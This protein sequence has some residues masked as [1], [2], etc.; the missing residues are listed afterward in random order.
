VAV[1][2][3]GFSFVPGMFS[4]F[5]YTMPPV[6]IGEPPMAALKLYL[7]PRKIAKKKY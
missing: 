6:M 4:N 1:L 5:F 3:V 2:L 7:L